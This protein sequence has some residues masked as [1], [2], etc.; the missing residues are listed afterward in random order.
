MTVEGSQL[1]LGVPKAKWYFGRDWV[2]N[3]EVTTSLPYHLTVVIRIRQV[4]SRVGK[5]LMRHAHVM[6]SSVPEL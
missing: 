6:A 5:A 3:R 2:F 4:R 1:G